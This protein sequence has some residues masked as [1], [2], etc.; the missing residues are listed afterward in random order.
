M[1]N[2][3][4]YFLQSGTGIVIESRNE[5]ASH[6]LPTYFNTREFSSFHRQLT[7]CKYTISFC[8]QLPLLRKKKT[9]FIIKDDRTQ[10]RIISLP[11]TCLH[12][13]DDI[14]MLQD[15]LI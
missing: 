3:I 10:P 5:L 4:P 1:L 8:T 12:K 11:A 7:N 9:I 2:H 13:P 15:T 14:T 6:V